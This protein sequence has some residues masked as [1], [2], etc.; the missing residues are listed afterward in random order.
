MAVMG[1]IIC[2]TFLW[3]APPEQGQAHASGT[4]RGSSALVI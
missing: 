2:N 4:R 3:Q 1:K